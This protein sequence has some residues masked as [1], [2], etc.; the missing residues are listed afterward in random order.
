MYARRSRS[1]SWLIGRYLRRSWT[2]RGATF[3]TTAEDEGQL[4]AVEL[5]FDS[6]Y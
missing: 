6:T 4:H 1:V 5:P 3:A 2:I